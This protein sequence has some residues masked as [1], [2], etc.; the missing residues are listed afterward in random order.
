MKIVVY[1]FVCFYRGWSTAVLGVNLLQGIILRWNLV[2][3]TAF[4]EIH[5]DSHKFDLYQ[6]I[7]F[8]TL[9]QYVEVDRDSECISL[10]QGWG[11]SFN[12]VRECQDFKL[13]TVSAI[14]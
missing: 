1:C 6:Q 4:L 5:P 7:G 8:L 11:K 14:H 13:L 9:C 2:A 12:N 10:R 3:E